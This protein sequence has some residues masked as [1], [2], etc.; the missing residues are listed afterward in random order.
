MKD[1]D[2]YLEKLGEIGFV[3]EVLHSIVSVSG[4]PEAHPNEVV[5]FESGDVGQIMSIKEDAVEILILSRTK[6][7]V[8]S[9]VVR[10]AE[11]LQIP[12]GEEFL[13]RFVDSLGNPLDG[14]KAIKGTYSP[15]DTQ[16]HGIVGRRQ[17][18]R[19]METGVTVVDLVVPLSMGQRELV[20]GDR[21]T[22]KTQFLLQMFLNQAKKG[23]VC[24]YAVIGQRQVDIKKRAEF[25][26]EN[27]I[28]GNTMVV[29]T[30]SSDPSGLIFLTQYA[31]MTY[32]EY[33]RDKGMDVLLILD[34]MTSHAKY[35]REV[36]LLAKR[37]PGR[38][39]YPGDI[40]YAQARLLE[41]AGNF[42][43]GSITCIP[44]SESVL[45]DLSGYIQTNLMAMT[46]GHIFFDIELYNQGM[47]PSVSP[48]LSV[49]R[50]GHQAQTPLQR[51]LSRQLSRF[52]VNYDRMKQFM[53]FGAEMG[54]T[55]KKTLD[56]GRRIDLFINQ[57]SS[58]L[59]PINANIIIIAGIWAGIWNE[60]DI[61]QLKK[62]IEQ[63]SIN[64]K[65]NEEYR[66]KIDGLLKS[67]SDFTELVNAV[68]RNNE[69]ISIN[70]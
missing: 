67:F 10:T 63:I 28:K 2:Y 45:G 15:I 29:A 33:F 21:K 7:K 69:T 31:A 39:S 20:I 13:G 9:K 60:T 6:I 42:K 65:T 68:R 4:L 27:N 38:S 17:I 8:G 24:I 19:P 47:R 3:E 53:H 54:D 14:G 58:V 70:A 41:R 32:A 35:Y 26:N 62:E 48:S 50:V 49:T 5:L 59:I 51:D 36:S 64:Y 66:K 16:P 61:G 1:F 25:I 22:G 55:V 43:T 57:P 40:F 37:F 46:D 56:L 44:V 23:T 11:L 34:D 30:S 12:V 18:D 52:L